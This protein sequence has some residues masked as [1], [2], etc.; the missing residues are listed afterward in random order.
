M[1]RP[2]SKA[3]ASA[4]PA[5]SSQY[6]YVWMEATRMEFDGLVAAGTFAEVNETP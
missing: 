5:C 4:V 1:S 6:S 3:G 2:G